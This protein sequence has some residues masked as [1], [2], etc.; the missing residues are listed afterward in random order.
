[1]N[2]PPRDFVLR[3]MG[4]VLLALI[5]VVAMAF[6]PWDAA[7]GLLVLG[8]LPTLTAASSGP[9]AMAAAAGASAIT[10]FL[11][12]LAAH[13]GPWTPVLGV[14]LVVA[15]SLA[16]G[17]LAVQGLHPIGAATISLAA[18]VMVDP[19]SAVA[20]LGDQLP[21]AAA[22]G[23]VAAAILLG[24]AWV[25]IVV[26]VVLRDVRLPTNRDAATLPYGLLLAGLCGVFTL[27]CMLWFSGTNAW[28]AVLTVAVIL[29]PTHGQT[30]TKLY[31]RILGTVLG[32]TVAALAVLVLPNAVAILLGVV[33]SL[34][35]VLLLMAGADY[36]QY[37]VA[38]T[39][40]VILLTFDS[41]EV[42]AGDLQRVT[43]TV[44]AAVATAVAVS[45]ATRLAP[46]VVLE[47]SGAE[48]EP[49]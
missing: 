32:G 19:S 42:I 24:C 26:S 49:R 36:W 6:S 46:A 27:V 14:L 8:M 7:T 47:T 48:P 38:V 33:A 21:F 15:L 37:S 43:V 9:A 17:A 44:A 1:M 11:A 35:C 3:V 22:A 10:A 40:S 41:S 39:M 28:W 13:S 45:I 23:L 30:R 12:V 20:V 4:A 5:P 2:L 16:T 18:Y 25:F 31:G 29:Q 34:A